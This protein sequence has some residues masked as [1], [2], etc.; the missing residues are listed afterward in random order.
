[1]IIIITIHEIGKKKR[2]KI[3]KK[4]KNGEQIGADLEVMR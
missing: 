3:T 1:M 2:E 4:K